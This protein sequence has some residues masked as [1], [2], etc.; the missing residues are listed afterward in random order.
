V[1]ETGHRE[2]SRR[3]DQTPTGEVDALARDGLI[4]TGWEGAARYYPSK[5]DWRRASTRAL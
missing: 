2:L 3:R 4:R 5:N 1:R